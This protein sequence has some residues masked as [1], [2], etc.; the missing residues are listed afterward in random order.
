MQPTPPCQTPTC[1]WKT[2][3]SG[4]LLCWQLQL[5][6]YSEFCFLSPSY[7]AFWDS[8]TSHRPACERVSYWVEASPHLRFPPQD[9]S[10]S[11]TPLSH[12]FSFIFC[13]TS[14]WRKWAAFLGAWCPSPA[15]RSCSVEVA[16]HSNDL[17]MILW[18]RKWL[19]HPI[20][21]PSWNCPWH[22]WF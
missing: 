6:S 15:F 20:P 10:W 7:V 3:P 16:Q 19:P 1:W 17:L 11:L 13:P 12:F 5:G 2:Q 9:E 21:L 8:K 4:L 14:F 18:G 22:L